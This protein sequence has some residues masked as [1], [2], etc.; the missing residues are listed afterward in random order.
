MKDFHDRCYY[1]VLGLMEDRA[2]AQMVCVGLDRV[3]AARQIAQIAIGWRLK[4]V[5]PPLIICT[6]AQMPKK[7]GPAYSATSR[8]VGCDLK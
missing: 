1:P 4:Q 7:F 3:N 8:L 2:Y 6:R 5:Q